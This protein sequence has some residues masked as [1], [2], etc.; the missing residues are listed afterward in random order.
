MRYAHFA[1][2]GFFA[3]PKFRSAFQVDERQFQHFGRERRTAGARSPLVLSGLV[4]AGANKVETP[5][6]GI[7]T[8]EGIV[9]LRLEDL[10]LAVLS[11][12]ETGL[13][14]VAGGEGVFGLQRAFHVAGAKNVIASL[15][16]VDDE[17]TAALMGL[18]YRNLWV[19]KNEP[20]EAL[21]Q[22]QLTCT[23]TRSRSRRWQNCARAS[24]ISDQSRCRRKPPSRQPKGAKTHAGKWA[25]FVLSGVGR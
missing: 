14:E 21:R 17:A 16:K 5:D 10:D 1:T 11:A 4:F 25:G 8:A 22:A 2:H 9:G 20:L 23:G 12:C 24:S 13:G 18:F 6:R 7:L 3:D 15:W 19:E